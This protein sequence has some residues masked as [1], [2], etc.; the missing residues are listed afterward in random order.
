IARRQA[1]EYF[2]RKNFD[3]PDFLK[4]R[5]YYSRYE[6]PMGTEY[7]G[8]TE[9][10]FTNVNTYLGNDPGPYRGIDLESNLQAS[11]SRVLP[12]VVL[13]VTRVSKLRWITGYGLN[14][15][16]IL[17]GWGYELSALDKAS[18]GA[19]VTVAFQTKEAAS[20]FYD[21]HYTRSFNQQIDAM[22]KYYKVHR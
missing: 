12:K 7:S 3:N 19:S 14:D 8:F 22:K 18:N 6:D 21:R 20:K 17:E 13:N 2:V 5:K 11:I 15:A 1:E 16:K 9:Q 10:G 4:L